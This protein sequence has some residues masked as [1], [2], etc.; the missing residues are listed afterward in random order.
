MVVNAGQ[1]RMELL[2]AGYGVVVEEADVSGQPPDDHPDRPATWL[3]S[4]TDK[5]SGEIAQKHYGRGATPDEAVASAWDRYRTDR[6]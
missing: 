3:A 5:S 2:R 6:A 1:A 4:L